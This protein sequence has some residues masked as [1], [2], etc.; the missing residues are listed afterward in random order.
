MALPAIFL[1]THDYILRPKR[2]VIELHTF[3]KGV[4]DLIETLYIHNNYVCIMLCVECMQVCL[5]DMGM[6]LHQLSRIVS[7]R[8]HLHLS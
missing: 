4:I 3:G 5:G 7:M 6:R 8:L 1:I 2:L